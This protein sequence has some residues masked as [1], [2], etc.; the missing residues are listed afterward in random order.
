[1]P[2]TY[3]LEHPDGTPVDPPNAALAAALLL[4]VLV[5]G[6]CGGGSG[7]SVTHYESTPDELEPLDVDYAKKSCIENFA[8]SGTWDGALRATDGG[9]TYEEDDLSNREIE[10]GC[11]L[12]RE[13]LEREGRA[14][15]LSETDREIRDRIVYL[16][17]NSGS[18]VHERPGGP[19]YGRD[20]VSFDWD[21]AII[22]GAIAPEVVRELEHQFEDVEFTA[23]SPFRLKWEVKE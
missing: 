15:E 12:A 5:L 16:V 20:A 10:E 4:I 3:K 18:P 9:N 8:H 2:I 17:T 23:T 6:G 1:M 22:T 13:Q 11:R 19:T 14:E 7:L 21:G